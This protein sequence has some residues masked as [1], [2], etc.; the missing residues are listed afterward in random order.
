MAD[1]HTPTTLVDWLDDLTVRFLLNLPSS[2]LSSVPRLCFQVEEAQWFYE[3]FVRPAVAASG[4]PPLPS[5]PLRQFCLLLFQHCPL[6]NGFS[7]EQHLKAYEE[8]LA[9]KVRVPVRGAIMVDERMEKVVLVRGWK[10]GASW[11]FPRGK[12]NK[13]EKDLDCAVRE[14]WEETGFD[15]RASG[16]VAENEED[17][18]KIDVT[19]REQ[20]MRLFVFRG[21][22]EDTHFE[23][24]T[25]KEI[26]KIQWYYI[27]DLPGF[28]KHKP[29]QPPS[30]DAVNA[31]KFY[32]VA[33]FLGH[34]KKWINQQR[35]ED[36]AR[37]ER[38]SA[39]G[40]GY[41]VQTGTEDEGDSELQEDVLPRR[42]SGV[43]V[44]SEDSKKLL[45]M[46]GFAAP[47]ATD[48]PNKTPSDSANLLAML[49]GN[50]K[51]TNGNQF[52]RT[53][54]DQINAF[55][56]QPESP[57]P[58]HMR[59]PSSSEQQRYS[60]PRFPLS[61]PR[62][63]QDPGR[64]F[65]LPTPNIFGPSYES[66]PP[67]NQQP[68]GYYGIPPHMQQQQAPP[69]RQSMPPM[70]L[71][72]V[73]P[74]GQQNSRDTNMP[75][76]MQQPHQT[77]HQIPPHMLPPHMQPQPP[78]FQPQGPPHNPFVAP[79]GQGA[80]RSGPDVPNASQLPAPRQLGAEKM[81]LLDAFRNPSGKA[82][83]PN[84]SVPAQPPKQR[85]AS[86]HQA[87]LLDL[88]RKPSEPA[89]PIPAP[90]SNAESVPESQEVLEPASPTGTD[91]TVKPS[92]RRRPTLNEITRTLPMA[93]P[94]VKSPATASGPPTPQS[95]DAPSMPA[96]TAAAMPARTQPRTN[97]PR[98]LFDPNNPMK[99]TPASLMQNPKSDG[100]QPVRKPQSRE[101]KNATSSGSPSRNTTGVQGSSQNGHRAAPP[102]FTILARPGSAKGGP[103][104]PAAPPSP[105]RNKSSKPAFHPQVLKRPKGTDAAEGE[106]KPADKKD[107][108]L[109]LFGKSTP[110][111]TSAPPA[112]WSV[113]SKP[114]A[115]ERRESTGDPKDRLLDLLNPSRPTAAPSTAPPPAPRI[116]PEQRP[117]SSRQ[118]P[119]LNTAMSRPAQNQQQNL[120]LDL[121]TNKRQ[122]TPTTSPGTPISPF[123]LGTPAVEEQKRRQQ[124]LTGLAN[125]SAA[126]AAE[127]G[128]QSP[129]EKK[130]FLMGFL[131]GVVRNEGYRGA[132][133]AGRK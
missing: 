57:H 81:R 114:A 3:D 83:P 84:A 39:N 88:F 89:K 36:A 67:F 42:E 17:V 74:F 103:K 108:L 38:Q 129:Q 53:P 52:P 46:G 110:S 45:S 11:S 126:G 128:A 18:K 60:P 20:H 106:Q 34:L 63:Q 49:Q 118:Q 15:I 77:M 107:Q 86:T 122:G 78:P 76:N 35:K 6:F 47:L 10:K 79:Q 31:N 40:Q 66:F 85:P 58:H 59:Q 23:P 61:P 87:A 13:D 27:K 54:F 111:N 98:Q 90:E 96:Q 102:P 43:E 124:S 113:D 37:A 12:I 64:P 4:A 69:Q 131:N 80:I 21:V 2:E 73:P 22:P 99:F 132:G 109:A 70:P 25:R 29:G 65:S 94:K 68:P 115:L 5:L 91:V 28:K 55:P 30:G 62:S 130:D 16:L 50:R 9:Y 119:P 93:E 121:F 123:T 26:S 104:S 14:V 100:Q 72:G 41:T 127:S 112:F 8:F 105:L 97:G 92:T 32:M 1:P 48:S 116:E 7:G 33:P 120:L 51:P 71:P 75:F 117:I 19:M 95:A 24:K 44:E 125:V 133:A 56:Q 82:A 101:P